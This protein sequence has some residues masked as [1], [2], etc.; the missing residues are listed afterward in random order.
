MSA[1]ERRRTGA[2]ST[3][4]LLAAIVAG[5]TINDAAAVAGMSPAT[6]HRRLG[7]LPVRR[8]LDALRLRV[9]ER[10]TD[11]LSNAAAGA[12]STVIE[13]MTDTANPPSVRLRAADVILTRVGPMRETTWSEQRLA[14]L[15][16]ADDRRRDAQQARWPA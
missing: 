14:E 4:K 8:R 1:D 15:E 3:D 13:I 16:A 11:A 2:G 5:R 7:E 6:A 9:A 10:V 12:L